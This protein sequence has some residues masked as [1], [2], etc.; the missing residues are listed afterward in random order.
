MCSSCRANVYL[1]QAS[2]SPRHPATVV[3]P[4]G[5]VVVPRTRPPSIL[6]RALSDLPVLT[7]ADE[8]LNDGLAALS[9]RLAE[10]L[11]EVGRPHSPPLTPKRLETRFRTLRPSPTATVVRKA[12]YAAR[13]AI[14]ART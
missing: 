3:L 4:N 5:V 2:D 8:M 1:I 11:E 6:E 14:I 10:L 13:H 12:P 7:G 9:E